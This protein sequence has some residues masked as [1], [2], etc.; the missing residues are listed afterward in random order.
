[1]HLLLAWNT[2]R[3]Y[4]FVDHLHQCG[5][6][7]I[8]DWVPAHFPKDGHGYHFDGTALFEHADPRK[9]QLRWGTS[10]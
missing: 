2:S 10:L 3:L 6:S 9:E 8:L 1:M 5:I 7:V 4:G